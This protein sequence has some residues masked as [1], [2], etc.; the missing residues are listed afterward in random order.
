VARTGPPAKDPA[1]RQR[2]GAAHLVVVPPPDLPAETDDRPSPPVRL[3]QAAREAWLGYF[4]SPVARA[5][6]PDADLPL[7][8]R[9]AS[10][11]D[12]WDRINVALRKQDRVVSGSLG[13]PVLNPLVGYLLKLEQLIG[14]AERELGLTPLARASL[15]LTQ[16]Q[17]RLTVAQINEHINRARPGTGEQGD[18]AELL[19]AEFEAGP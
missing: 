19:D 2:R 3:R 4:R 15:G 7:L 9:W 12:E 18:V 8:T 10:Y 16:G 17:A 11:L 6:D 5:F 13:Q 14:R 1:T